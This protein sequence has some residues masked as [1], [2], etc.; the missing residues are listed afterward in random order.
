M[1]YIAMSPANIQLMLQN[2]AQQL[3]TYISWL[4]QRVQAYNNLTTNVMTA[5]GIT[6]G[7]TQNTIL[8]FIADINR[9]Y[10]YSTGVAQGVAADMRFD[11]AA[12][13]GV[14]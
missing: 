14:L 6:D 5:A 7:P 8:A 4:E 2:D 1:T 10:L 3:R 12:I 9:G 13:L 11:C